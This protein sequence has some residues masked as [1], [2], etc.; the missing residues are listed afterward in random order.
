MRVT[1]GRSK[2]VFCESQNDQQHTARNCRAAKNALRWKWRRP[3]PE[4][5]AILIFEL[6]RSHSANSMSRPP[7]GVS[8]SHLQDNLFI[9]LPSAVVRFIV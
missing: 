9:S 2:G 1:R 3:K 6:A 7:E 4:A 5:S 8:I